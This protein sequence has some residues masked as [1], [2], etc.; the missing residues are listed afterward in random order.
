MRAAIGPARAHHR[1]GTPVEVCGQLPGRK[2]S[3]G[4]IGGSGRLGRARECPFLHSTQFFAHTPFLMGTPRTRRCGQPRAPLRS[5]RGRRVRPGGCHPEN[6]LGPWE[7]L[8]RSN[9]IKR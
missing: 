2:P 9:Y 3:F 6:E 7:R 1:E 4:W 5:L 8:R